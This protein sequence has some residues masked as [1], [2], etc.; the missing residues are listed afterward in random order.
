MM[1]AVLEVYVLEKQRSVLD[2]CCEQLKFISQLLLLV[3]F[4][5]TAIVNSEFLLTEFNQGEH[6]SSGTAKSV[7]HTSPLVSPIRWTASGCF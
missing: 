7:Q 5:S 3:L 4:T 1:D 6:C 2:H